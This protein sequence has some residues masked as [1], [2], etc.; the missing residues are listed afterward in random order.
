MGEQKWRR[1]DQ[2]S[3]NRGRNRDNN[4][5]LRGVFGYGVEF[6]GDELYCAYCRGECRFSAEM[7]VLADRGIAVIGAV[8]VSLSLAVRE[9]V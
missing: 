6:G 7:N 4:W 3:G 9:K 2:C 5:E 8:S 1:Y